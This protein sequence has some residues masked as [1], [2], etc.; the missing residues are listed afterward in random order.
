MKSMLQQPSN[1][2]G[3]FDSGMGGLTV[4]K[5]ITELLP[6]ENIV[7]FGDT[8]H[9]PWG[10]KSSA[11]IQAY[12]VKICDILL[13]HHCKYI[14][15]ACHTAST[16]ACDLVREYVG[17]KAHVINVVDPVVNHI[18]ENHTDHKIGLIGTK[19]TVRSNFYTKRIDLLNQNIELTALATPL[20]VPLIEEGFVEKEVTNIVIKEYLSNPILSNIQ[21]LILGCTH[22][23]LLKGYIQNFYQNTIDIIDASEMTA[24]VLKAHLTAQKLLNPGNSSQKIFYVSDYS[25]FFSST[26]KIF[27]P[28]DITL[29]P[30]PLWE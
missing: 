30:Y 14:V 7:Y 8:A 5:T 16:V 20:L 29:Q 24:K 9:V 23:P 21:A 4:A 27:F 17:N 1:P 26:A 25:E 10:D 11:A 15:I 13:Q 3:I 6:N 19:Q 18:R 22:Y 2:I 12:S 28:G